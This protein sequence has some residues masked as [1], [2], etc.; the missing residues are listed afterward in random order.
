MSKYSEYNIIPIG[1]HCAI[2]MILKDLS[3]RQKSYPFDWVTHQD[4]L[5]DTNIM[6]NLS[7]MDQLCKTEHVEEVVHMYLGDAFDNDRFNPATLMWF[8]HDTEAKADIFEKYNRRFARLKSDLSQKNMF[9]L[10]TRH[11]YI[12][13]TQFEKIIAQLLSYHPE[14]MILFISG[15]DHPYF[16]EM[17]NNNVIF[18]Y[19]HYDVAQFHDY[20]YTDFRPNI[21]KYL[22][23]LFS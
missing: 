1:D 6:Y 17:G 3:L 18:K 21:K 14:S 4:H 10:L 2:P 7:I 16:E 13:K 5:Y 11:Y 12:E 15:T 20:D 19:I 9:I 8:P 23:E 22:S